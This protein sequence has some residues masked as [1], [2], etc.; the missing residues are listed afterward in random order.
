MSE[1]AGYLRIKEIEIVRVVN[2]MI[3]FW[4]VEG[5]YGWLSNWSPHSIHEN[6]IVYKTVEHYFMWHK[7][8]AM[9]DTKT[10]QKILD[11]KSP[12]DAKKEGCNVK[13]WDESMWITIREKI[14][15]RGLQLK[16]EQHPSVKAKLLYT[17]DSVI[18][19]AS[20]YDAVWGIGCTSTDVRA[21]DQKLW[22]G[23]N[24]L[25]KQWMIVRE[26]FL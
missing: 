4:K 3:L 11:A 20:P 25:G 22:V 14:M 15:Q 21:L 13:P 18:A 1:T 17:R 26:Q 24:L 10:A 2:K 8:M 5:D 16:V 7:A 23:K 19:E 6:D 9:G 12:I